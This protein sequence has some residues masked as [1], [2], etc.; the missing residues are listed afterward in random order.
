MIIQLSTVPEADK[1]IIIAIMC[2]AAYKRLFG[3]PWIWLVFIIFRS[4]GLYEYLG[5]SVCVP[6]LCIHQ[7]VWMFC[8]HMDILHVYAQMSIVLLK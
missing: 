8:V 7:H 2:K 4:F 5:V 3:F 1:S 6:S